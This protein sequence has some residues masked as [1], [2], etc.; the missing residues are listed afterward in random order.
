MYDEFSS[1]Y[2]IQPEEVYGPEFS[3]V[4]DEEE[5]FELPLPASAWSVGFASD[6]VVVGHDGEYAD[7]SNPTGA[8]IRERFY[9]IAEDAKGNRRT[10][11]GLY[12]SQDAAEA[13]YALLAPAVALWEET[14]PCYGSEAW[15]SEVEAAEA[16]AEQADEL[17]SQYLNFRYE[18]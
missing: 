1:L 14:R 5:S 10:W 17:A 15:T 8:I 6:F 11:G 9:I 4:E 7:M 2:K 16:E 18:L 3:V 13:A 12:E